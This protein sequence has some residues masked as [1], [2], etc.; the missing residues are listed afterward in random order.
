MRIKPLGKFLAILT[1]FL[2]SAHNVLAVCTL[3]GEEVPCDQIP[4][5]V[6]L[7][8]IIMFAIAIFFFVFWILMLVDAIKNQ[9]EAA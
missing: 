5:F 8:P 4:K 3:N 2:S 1:V 9:K 6:F 7:I